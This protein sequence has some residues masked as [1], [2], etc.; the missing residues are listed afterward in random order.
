MATETTQ[1]RELGLKIFERWTRLW[2]GELALAEELIGE[3]FWVHLTVRSPQWTPERLRDAEAVAG[4][5]EWVRGRYQTIRYIMDGSPIVDTAQGTVVCPW[6][7][8]GV[9]AGRSGRPEDVAGQAFRQAGIDILRFEGERIV[10]CWTLSVNVTALG[11]SWPQP[12][13]R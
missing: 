6:H 2:N 10:E 5:V 1:A 7:A 8:D 3:G 12:R 9:F 4:W 13:R 11:D